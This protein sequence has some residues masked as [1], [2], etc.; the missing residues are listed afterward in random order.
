MKKTIILLLLVIFYVFPGIIFAD[1]NLGKILSGRILLQVETKG[2]AWYV[3]PINYQKYYLGSP[4][5]SYNILRNLGVG[6]T[7]TNLNKIPVG[8]GYFSDKDN[9]DDALPNRLEIA[10][11]TNP[12]E[13]DSDNDG[14]NDY[15]EIISGYNPLGN[16]KINI[17]K[18]FINKQNGKIFLQAEN[19][20]EAWYVNPT[21]NKR[22][23]LSRPSDAF[24]IMKSFGLGITNNNLNK[25]ISSNE[26]IKNNESSAE[27]I[28]KS[29]INAIRSGN[30]NEALTYFT[31]DAQII[32]NY[33][34]NFLDSEGKFTLANILSGAKKIESTEVQNTYFNEVDF[35]L[36]GYKVPLYFYIKKQSDGTWKMTNL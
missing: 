5:E 7:N 21:D 6:I 8:L 31:P 22:Y 17:D 28:F 25:I 27:Q 19:N 15:V 1:D 18:N 24:L 20:G 36:G 11:G 2:E 30:I 33:T 32:V 14:F 34:L 16:N 3:N 13:A 10:L 4:S 23:Y 35:S 12:N 9:D 26:I 29:V